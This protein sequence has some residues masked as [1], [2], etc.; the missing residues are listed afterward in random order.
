VKRKLL[1][2]L[3]CP[4]THKPLHAASPDVLERLNS[5]VTE[6]RLLRHDG[7]PVERRLEEALVTEDDKVAYPVEDGIPVLLEDEAI[8][9]AQLSTP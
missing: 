5:A 2:I 8:A 9:L 6:G 1:E 3:C 7:S 4:V